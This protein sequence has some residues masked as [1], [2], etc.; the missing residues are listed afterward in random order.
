MT[1]PAQPR[2]M[3][4]SISHDRLGETSKKIISIQGGYSHNF[5]EIKMAAASGCNCGLSGEE[6][7]LFLIF[8]IARVSHCP[9]AF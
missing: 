6:G 7:D 8:V 1:R 9:L 3:T 5:F 2:N 4:Q